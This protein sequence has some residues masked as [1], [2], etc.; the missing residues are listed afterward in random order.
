MGPNAYQTL[1]A[2]GLIIITGASGS[3]KDAVEDFM[4]GRLKEISSPTVGTHSGVAIS[5]GWG[6]GRGGGKGGGMGGGRRGQR[7]RT[8]R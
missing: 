4:K 7:N 2:G 8:V 6:T 5:G 3:V 1:S